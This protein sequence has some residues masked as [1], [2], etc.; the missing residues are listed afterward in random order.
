MAKADKPQSPQPQSDGSKTSKIV[1]KVLTILISI[2]VGRLVTKLIDRVWVAVRP[3]TPADRDDADA[4]DWKD[5]VA[6][7]ALSAA[8]MAA[9][10]LITKRGAESAYR[11]LVGT[12][13]PPVATHAEKKLAK[14]LE[15]AEEASA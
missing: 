8:G 13:P 7:A 6:W 11:A 3:S 10:Q 5:A 12:T 4:V 14:H 15:K 9:A 1:F 2:P